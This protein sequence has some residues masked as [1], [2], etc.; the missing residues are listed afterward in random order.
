MKEK[1]K[2]LWINSFIYRGID[3]MISARFRRKLKNDQ[4]TILCPNC[5]GGCIYHRLGKQFLTPTINLIINMH[6]FIPFCLN[7]DWYLAQTVQFAPSKKPYPVGYLS[8]NKERG[9]PDVQIEFNHDKIES[10]AA[11][12]W[13]RRK[14]RINRDNMYLIMYRWSGITAEELHLLDDYPC[15]NKILLSKIPDPIIS[16]EYYIDPGKTQDTYLTQD[17]F[18]VRLLE[19]K[20]DFVSFLN[21]GAQN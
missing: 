6:E 18:G 10:E 5:V 7:L 19:K 8:G 15:K 16:W 3:R 21:E 1:L 11:E 4:F 14:K 20:F 12:K 2:K 13:E 9:L 17:L